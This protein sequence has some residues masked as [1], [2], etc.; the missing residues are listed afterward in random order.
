MNQH[1]GLP[2]EQAMKEKALNDTLAHIKHKVFVM[3]G[4]GGVG[5][6]SVTVNLGVALALQGLRVG[7]LDVD[8]HGPSVPRL[9]G[10]ESSVMADEQ[11]RMQ[12]VMWQDKIAVISMDA[13]LSDRDSAIVW[14]G[15]VKS[16]VIK[17][18]LTDVVWGELDVLLIDSPPGTGDEHLTILHT[19][20]DAT[21]LVVTTP[22]EISL[23]DVRKA[24]DLLRQVKTPILGLVENMSGLACPHCGELIDLFC[25]H[26]GKMLAEKQQISFLG[27][28]PLDPTAVVAADRGVPAVTLEGD[29]AAKQA[30]MA[31]AADIADRLHK[32]S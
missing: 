18:F 5:K 30:F 2:L 1:T 32:K 16:G 7:I 6:S 12:P 23:A 20:T 14:R 3:S 28:I 11:G 17:Q 22:Q 21:A 15:P 9:L 24:L 31:L 4:K 25:K 19:I 10:L 27:A 26:G 29:S 8:I 13:L